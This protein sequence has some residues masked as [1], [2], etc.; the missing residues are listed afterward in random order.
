VKEIEK[1]AETSSSTLDSS[2]ISSL[3]S[4]LNREQEMEQFLAGVPGFY[5]SMRVENPA[6]VL[7]E[8]NTDRLPK[9][10]VAFMDHSLSS[11]FVSDAARRQRIAVALKAIQADSYL[12]QRTFYHALGFIESAV[13]TCIDFVLLCGS[14]HH[15]LRSGRSLPCR[16]HNCSRHQPRR[17]LYGRALGRHSSARVELVGVHL[18]R[19]PRTARQ[20]TTP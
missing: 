20:H 15:R 4:S 17:R 12:L 5:K 6:E 1:L 7:R 8:S 18:R 9:A 19:I 16:M 2:A 10:I 13:F 3:L 11:G 14:A